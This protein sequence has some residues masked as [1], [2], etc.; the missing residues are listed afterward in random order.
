MQIGERI[1]LTRQC[2][3]IRVPDGNIITLEEGTPVTIAQSLGDTYTVMTDMGM[4]AR[5][6]GTDADAIGKEPIKLPDLSESGLPIEEQVMAQLRTCYDPEIPVNIVELGLVYN[7]EVTPSPQ[8]GHDVNITMTLTAPGCG[9]GE[10]L[11]ADVRRKVASL[12][13]VRHVEVNVVFDPPWDRSRMSEAAQL[14]LGMM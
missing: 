1:K 9:M 14:Q 7:C 5:I 6:A 8:G 2:E 3:A 4:M 10:V 12:R 11:A 13:D